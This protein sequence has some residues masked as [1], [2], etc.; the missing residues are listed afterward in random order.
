MTASRPLIAA[1]VAATLCVSHPLFARA[2]THPVPPSAGVWQSTA[3]PLGETTRG[4]LL[5]SLRRITGLDGVAFRADGRLAIPDRRR[6]RA[7]S[8]TAEGILRMALASDDVFVVEEHSGTDRVTFGQIEPMT[9]I[10]DRASRRAQVWWVRLDFD[11][12][13][14]IEAPRRVRAAFD[15]GFVFLHE[16][17]HAQGHK[18]GTGP[19]DLGQ[20]ERILNYVRVELGLPLRADYAATRVAGLT[21]GTSQ[22]RL[23]FRDVRRGE[24]SQVVQHLSF[25]AAPPP[26]VDLVPLA[27]RVARAKS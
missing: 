23:R 14:T 7:G 5:T 3:H 22:A 12:F 18:D 17:L 13:E 11:D 10:D 19:G 25:D 20:C 26:A 27:A 24:R 2:E 6:T 16:L 8:R 21:R 1:A 15:A 9:Y 4:R